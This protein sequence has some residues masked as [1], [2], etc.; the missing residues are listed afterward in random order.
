VPGNGVGMDLAV[1][2][3]EV[4]DVSC[5]RREGKELP[6][7]LVDIVEDC[8]FVARVDDS[9]APAGAFAGAVY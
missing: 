7:W 6:C 4:E 5:C 3:E 2:P 9:L 1:P 8:L